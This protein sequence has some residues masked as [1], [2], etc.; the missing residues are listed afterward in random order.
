MKKIYILFLFISFFTFARELNW[1]NTADIEK[2]NNIA[3][4]GDLIIYKPRKNNVTQLWGHVM[5]VTENNKIVD[6]PNM[7]FGLREFPFSFLTADNREFILLRYKG[8]NDEIR[9]KL[10][11]KI[12]TKYL[13]FSYFILT[14][15]NMTIG[16]T[17]CSHFIYNLYR[18]VVGDVIENNSNLIYPLDFLNSKYFKIVDF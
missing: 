4:V 3:K 7:Q 12:Y 18:D 14:P 9:K 2:L 10:L 13:Y 17:Y 1:K 15:P 5:F 6:F 16:T 8:I 11:D